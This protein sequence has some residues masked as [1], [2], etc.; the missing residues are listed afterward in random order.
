L[1]DQ[2]HDRKTNREIQWINVDTRWQNNNGVKLLWNI[3]HSV[4]TINEQR[5][6]YNED[7]DDD[8]DE[9]D[10]DEGEDKCSHLWDSLP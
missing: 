5:W 1:A 9:D 6:R 10:D 8:D 2:G 3:I 7:T 4:R